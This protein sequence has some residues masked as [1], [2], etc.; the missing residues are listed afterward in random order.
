[1]LQVAVQNARD[2]HELLSAV[3]DPSAMSRETAEGLEFLLQELG[4]LSHEMKAGSSRCF[5]SHEPV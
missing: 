2:V 5:A 4:R 3:A 1:M